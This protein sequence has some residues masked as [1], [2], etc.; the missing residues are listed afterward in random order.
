[1]SKT[2]P[3]GVTADGR[4]CARVEAPLAEKKLSNC[5]ATIEGNY[6][7]TGEPI[8]PKLIVKDG[9]IVLKEGVDYEITSRGVQ[10]W[11]A[12]LVITGIGNYTGD[13]TVEYVIAK[14]NLKDAVVKSS[15][16]AG[17][18]KEL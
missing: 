2:N 8:S 13:L 11:Y 18:R 3:V 15:K 9:D 6:V 14:A 1:M 17:K 7:Y 16:E 10:F 4:Y 12:Y 5:T